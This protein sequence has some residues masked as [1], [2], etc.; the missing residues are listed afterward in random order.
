MDKRFFKFEIDGATYWVV[1]VDLDN[2]RDVL[3][4]SGA[5]FGQ[6]GESLDSATERGLVSSKEI[7]GTRVKVDTS[8]D[9]RGRGMIPLSEC[10]LGEWF[11]SEY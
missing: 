8:E 7:T 6:E 4:E 11:T 5:E 1:A 2:A 3:R 10:D 9:D